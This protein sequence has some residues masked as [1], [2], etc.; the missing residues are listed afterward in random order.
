MILDLNHLERLDPQQRQQIEQL[1]EQHPYLKSKMETA[2][3]L[4]TGTQPTPAAVPPP[5]P[6]P[7][8]PMANAAEARKAAAAEVL[9]YEALK[10]DASAPYTPSAPPVR[11]TI[12]VDPKAHSFS[13]IGEEET[14]AKEEEEKPKKAEPTLASGQTFSPD[15]KEHPVLSKMKVLLGMRSADPDPVRIKIGGVEYGFRQVNREKMVQANTIAM[16]DSFDDSQYRA[17]IETA[18]LAHAVVEIDRLPKEVVFQI[19]E[20][21]TNLLG[22]FKTYSI[23][24]RRARSSEMFYEFLKEAPP[25]LTNT[26]VSMYD[27]EF[28]GVDLLEPGKQFYFCPEAECQYKRV[29]G[30]G[31]KG[32]CPL[33]GREL[34]A[35]ADL[36]NPS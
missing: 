30:N 13:R 5:P 34:V 25:E 29:L 27:Q 2:R 32:Y 1:I 24:E 4:D 20:S 18:I 28:P 35:E 14:A 6:P 33:H 22:E 16:R 3:Q 11:P 23:S 8:P 19:P 12:K 36:P 17:N 26:L 31:Q 10:P 7:P 15:G 21:E 9:D